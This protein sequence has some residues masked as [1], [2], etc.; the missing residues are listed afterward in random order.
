MTALQQSLLA[1][2]AWFDLF[3]YPL[4]AWEV[5][6][7]LCIGNDKAGFG[8]SSSYEE[9]LEG[10]R[11]LVAEKAIESQWSFFFLVGRKE[12]VEIRR[13]RYLIADAKFTRARYVASLFRFVPWVRMVAV[14]NTL[15]YSNAAHES[16]I[17][18]LII[19]S[20]GRLWTVRA[21]CLALLVLLGLRPSLQRFG[22]KQEERKDKID[23]TFF[24]GEDALDLSRL[25]LKGD[26]SALIPD[27]YFVY[28]LVQLTPL[29]DKGGVYER[30]WEA[31][32]TLRQ[33]VPHTL[34]YLTSPLR[35]VSE[36]V[37]IIQKIFELLLWGRRA[38]RL[39]R[40]VQLAIMPLRLR[41]EASRHRGVVL[42]EHVLKFHDHDRREEYRERWFKLIKSQITISKSQINL[43]IQ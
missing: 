23:L 3:D 31:N 8:A 7:W 34:P 19:T 13:N 42:D 10:L 22:A 26:A 35:R 28:W 18:F 24:V 32:H 1:T 2:L 11:A 36:R 6:T 5:Y 21:V 17:D 43:N 30:F 37:Q 27:P 38:E 15:G 12:T 20:S 41:E 9:V 4:T 39:L 25:S 14:C 16:D 40:R 33:S 29:L